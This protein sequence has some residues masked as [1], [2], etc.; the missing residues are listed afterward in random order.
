MS[1]TMNSSIKQKCPYCDNFYDKESLVDD[2]GIIQCNLCFS[3]LEIHSTFKIN[4][5]KDDTD[6]RIKQSIE[7]SDDNIYDD[8][9]NS[10][11]KL[12]FSSPNIKSN[13]NIRTSKRKDID[14]MSKISLLYSSIWQTTNTYLKDIIKNKDLSVDESNYL[15]SN[16]VDILNHCSII[17]SGKYDHYEGNIQ[18]PKEY[19]VRVC[20]AVLFVVRC[21]K[22]LL[23]KI[24]L[25]YISKYYYQLCKNK[26]GANGFIHGIYSFLSVIQEYKLGSLIYSN[27]QLV[28][29]K[30]N[31]NINKPLDCSLDEH[32]SIGVVVQSNETSTQHLEEPCSWYVSCVNL[33]EILLLTFFERYPEYELFK[34][35]SINS[36]RYVMDNVKFEGKGPKLSMAICIYIVG[37]LSFKIISY[38]DDLMND[39]N[40]YKTS[41]MDIETSI[42]IPISRKR[43][44]TSL[45]KRIDV[46]ENNEKDKGSILLD[47][48]IEYFLYKMEIN[49]QIKDKKR[50]Q[51][52]KYIHKFIQSYV[53]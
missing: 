53:N 8:F 13:K 36:Y 9:D 39:F 52:V 3:V 23:K 11:N 46:N 42:D 15:V 10:N 26:K 43:R 47:H 24:D 34:L 19:I 22:R 4:N 38:S 48:I 16:V 45:K 37:L 29:H 20:A 50:Q 1:F 5:L 30:N 12:G 32:I 28:D 33:Y 17:W 31:E 40:I 25:N 49:P 21:D 27:S 6:D 51:F 2:S 41:S 7:Y 14:G 18:L 44:K 35:D